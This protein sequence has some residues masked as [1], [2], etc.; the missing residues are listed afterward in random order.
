MRI[1]IITILALLCLKAN[2]QLTHGGNP[3][4]DL[5]KD[6]GK[7]NIPTIKLK[8]FTKDEISEMTSNDTVSFII[9]KSID[10]NINVLNEASIIET[11]NNK[12]Y[13]LKIKTDNALAL[14]LM[15]STFVLPK[16]AKMY[17]WSNNSY[18]GAYT[19]ENMRPDSTFHFATISGNELIIEI[20]IPT[21]FEKNNTIQL[22]LNKTGYFFKDLFTQFSTGESGESSDCNNNVNCEEWIC[23]CNQIR[24][25]VIYAYPYEDNWWGTCSGAMVNNYD[26]DFT[27][28]LLT[29]E[30]CIDEDKDHGLPVFSNTKVH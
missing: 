2:S 24:S 22:D 11:K 14:N 25:T 27:P 28:Y 19:Y 21:I 20:D 30:H 1:F 29:A 7:Y 10:V 17:V 12:T 26:Q 5:R 23:W 16:E 9:G 15:F 6:Q 3:I 8:D 4:I 18:Y 13:L